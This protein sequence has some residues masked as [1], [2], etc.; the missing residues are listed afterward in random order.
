MIT[1]AIKGDPTPSADAIAATPTTR[2]AV[3]SATHASVRAPRAGER[4]SAR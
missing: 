1:A 4:P 3:A 2:A